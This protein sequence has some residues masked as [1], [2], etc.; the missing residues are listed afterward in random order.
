M[1]E[2]NDTKKSLK[3]DLTDE[4][5]LE[6]VN[7][8]INVF[9]EYNSENPEK[10]P[11]VWRSLDIILNQMKDDKENDGDSKAEGDD[12]LVE[13]MTSLLSDYIPKDAKIGAFRDFGEKVSELSKIPLPRAF[14]KKIH[15]LEWF[16]LY[17]NDIEP[18]LQ[19][20]DLNDSNLSNDIDQNDITYDEI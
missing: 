4:K 9:R 2:S 1:T 11:T 14:Q 17:W 3:G 10:A 13:E 18:Y 7:N 8:I 20:P 12:A 19:V 5:L 16:K 15:I 6:E